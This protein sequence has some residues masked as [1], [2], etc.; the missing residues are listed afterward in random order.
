MPFFIVF[1]VRVAVVGLELGAVVSLSYTFP[2]AGLY[3]LD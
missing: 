1:N 3:F 2:V